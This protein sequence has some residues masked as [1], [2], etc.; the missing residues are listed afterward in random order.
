MLISKSIIKTL[1]D[2]QSTIVF[3]PLPLDD[4]KNRNPD[5][6]L[7]KKLLDWE[8]ETDL[9][10]GLKKTIN[11]MKTDMSV[12]NLSEENLSVN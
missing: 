7:A 2:T 6:G 11:Y 12:K 10:D 8:P 1:I 3:C 5:I 4:P 9:I